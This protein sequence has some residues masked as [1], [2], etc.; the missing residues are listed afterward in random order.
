MEEY[1]I[2]FI[3]KI[4]GNVEYEKRI[5]EL[6]KMVLPSHVSV[7]EMEHCLGNDHFI[8]FLDEIMNNGGD[9]GLGCQ[10]HSKSYYELKTLDHSWCS[11][12]SC[13]SNSCHWASSWSN[14]YGTCSTS[15]T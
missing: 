9:N 7:V 1:E 12:S 10:V 13:T 5:E 8:Q 2:C 4:I 15:T 11:Q 3:C 6:T 14:Y